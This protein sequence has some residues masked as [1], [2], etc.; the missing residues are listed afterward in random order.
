MIFSFLPR[1]SHILLHR[2][3]LLTSLLR[4]LR[5]QSLNRIPQTQTHSQFF[6]QRLFANWTR[7]LSLSLH[8]LVIA[9]LAKVMS[10]GSHNGLVEEFVA[11]RALELGQQV[12]GFLLFGGL[13]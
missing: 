12:C 10:T 3:Y 9:V 1:R 2:F 6:G 11:N 4:L 5:K 13:L 8:P 7:W